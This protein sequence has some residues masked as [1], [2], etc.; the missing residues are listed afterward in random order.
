MTYDGFGGHARLEEFPSGKHDY[1]SLTSY[2]KKIK[3]ETKRKKTK[4]DTGDNK[5]LNDM[6]SDRCLYRQ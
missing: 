3:M 4:L 1:S 6:L 2:A 5:K